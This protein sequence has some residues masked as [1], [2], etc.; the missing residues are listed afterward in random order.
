MFC[1]W[2]SN[3]QYNALCYICFTGSS[4]NA[5]EH[6]VC[7]HLETDIFE[8]KGGNNYRVHELHYPG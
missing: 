7:S 1:Y 3:L 2:V 4:N 6:Q 8:I 5:L